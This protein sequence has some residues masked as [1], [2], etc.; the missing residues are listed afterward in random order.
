MALRDEGTYPLR[1]FVM[2]KEVRDGISGENLLGS[3]DLIY[4]YVMSIFSWTIPIQFS[5]K[6]GRFYPQSSCW[7]DLLLNYGI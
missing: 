7:L 3:K 2:M 1:V 6:S 4:Q 5:P